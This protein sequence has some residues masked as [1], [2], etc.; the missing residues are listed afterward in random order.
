MKQDTMQRLRAA[1]PI[2]DE[3]IDGLAP[4][5][6]HTAPAVTDGFASDG[7]RRNAAR[8]RRLRRGG[9]VF[10]LVGALVVGGAVGA[11]AGGIT[12]STPAPLATVWDNTITNQPD[13]SSIHDESDERAD[14]DVSAASVTTILNQM[15]AA[16]PLPP[17]A[18]AAKV[19]ALLYRTFPM[20]VGGDFPLDY[21]EEA[22]YFYGLG[23]ETQ[24]DGVDADTSQV[25]KISQAGLS[26]TVALIAAHTWYEYWLKANP[27]QR[28]AAQPVLDNMQTWADLSFRLSFGGTPTIIEVARVAEA[29]AHND[30]YPMQQWLKKLRHP[31][32]A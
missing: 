3:Q 9:V 6:L 21:P 18:K 22:Q 28:K 10:G 27:A 12:A 1:N 8:S 29:A 14:I 19:Y 23:Y 5:Q 30:G 17:G 7:E 20:P 25:G 15:T 31:D 11:T 26:G 13:K 16:Y 24:G 4:M 32:G 2:S